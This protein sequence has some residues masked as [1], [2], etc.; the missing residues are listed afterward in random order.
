MFPPA[1]L[2]RR[3]EGRL[4]L[5]RRL[6]GRLGQKLAQ[7]ATLTVVFGLRLSESGALRGAWVD[8]VAAQRWRMEESLTAQWILTVFLLVVAI[9]FGIYGFSQY[10]NR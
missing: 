7:R 9:G 1:N 10:R 5:T 3:L 4:G 6:E 2:T 8:H